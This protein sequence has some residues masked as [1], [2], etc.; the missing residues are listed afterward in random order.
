[1]NMF[2]ACLA[3]PVAAVEPDEAPNHPAWKTKKWVGEIT[4]RLYTRY[5][6]EPVPP[7]SVAAP[8]VLRAH[9]RK[10]FKQKM[11]RDRG[12]VHMAGAGGRGCGHMGRMQ[13]SA[14]VQGRMV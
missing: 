7:S 4:T 10:A 6:A 9:T 12:A 2:M 1:M 5:G 14:L 13:E 3:K 8:S 11:I